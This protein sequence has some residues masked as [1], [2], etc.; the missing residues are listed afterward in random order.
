MLQKVFGVYFKCR[1]LAIRGFDVLHQLGI[2]M[3]S[4]WAQNTLKGIAK[5]NMDTVANYVEKMLII[6]T[7]DNI[8]IKRIVYE[9]RANHQTS[10]DNGAAATGFV[11][12]NQLPLSPDQVKR[13]KAAR[14]EGILNPVDCSFVFELEETAN[15][16][17]HPHI[18]HRI[19]QIL[20]DAPEFDLKTYRYRD[21]HLFEPPHALHPLPHGPD[22]TVI[23]FI[24]RTVKMEET[25]Y[26]GNDN[27]VKEWLRQ[28]KL[29]SLADRAKLGTEMMIPIVGDQLTVERL[30]NFYKFRAED[31]SSFERMEHLLETF[32]WFHL[33]MIFAVSLHKQHYGTAATRGLAHDFSLLKKRG[34]SRAI[35]K[36]PFFHHLDEA[37]NHRVDAHIRYAW[38]VTAKVAKLSDLREHSPDQ[39]ISLAERIYEEHASTLALDKMALKKS[40]DIRRQAVMWN[41]DAL[42][43]VTLGK[44]VKEG[45]VGIMEAMLPHL[46]FRFI[47]GRNKKYTGEILELIQMLHRELP[48]DVR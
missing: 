4:T 14:A 10:F 9:Q 24:L 6:L 36:G 17:L 15:R 30:R 43:Y 5:D 34:V 1:Q 13:I 12:K 48:S 32:G 19:L 2:T 22:D 42:H 20:L 7:Y 40:D 11:K 16:A 27:V 29:D 38:M 21:T 26:E 18:R 28:L 39:L 46:L 47:G 45:D 3:S 37:I 35:T 41:R 25:S 33:E 23:Q 31:F 44:A 8:N